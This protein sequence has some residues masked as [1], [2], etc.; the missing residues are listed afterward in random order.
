M[1]LGRPHC[2]SRVL[3]ERPLSGA[4]DPAGGRGGCG[5]VHP[6][7]IIYAYVYDIHI[8][9]RLRHV[10]LP[11]YTRICIVYRILLRGVFKEGIGLQDLIAQ[12]ELLMQHF[13]AGGQWLVLVGGQG[14]PGLGGDLLA[15]VVL[16]L[17]AAGVVLE[18]ALEED[19]EGVLQLGGC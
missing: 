17:L 7:V 10:L 1:I 6:V 16:R 9:T 3:P 2:A 19:L 15:A 4:V 12:V 14:L 8:S 18:P 13:V 11:L 5:R